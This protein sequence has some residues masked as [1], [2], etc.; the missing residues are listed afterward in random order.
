MGALA[1]GQAGAAAPAGACAAAPADQRLALVV[2]C[3]WRVVH[4]YA[5]QLTCTACQRSGSSASEEQ[6]HARIGASTTRSVPIV[7]V[8]ASF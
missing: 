7:L 8:L 3:T 1:L 5:G 2:P 6:W 4:R